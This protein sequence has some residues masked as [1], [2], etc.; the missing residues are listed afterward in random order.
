MSKPG[1]IFAYVAR[2]NTKADN[3][4]ELYIDKK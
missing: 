2:A 4:V 3:F 1:V